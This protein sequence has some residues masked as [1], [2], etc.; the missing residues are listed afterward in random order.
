MFYK[1]IKEL[2]NELNCENV[3]TLKPQIIRKVNQLILSIN[4]DN[5]F[6]ERIW[7]RT[8]K[9]NLFLGQFN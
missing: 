7:D 5:K 4:D 8:S 6:K 3:E 9:K 1:E 2:L